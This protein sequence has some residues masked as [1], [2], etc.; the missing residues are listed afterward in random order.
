MELRD[1]RFVYVH[2]VGNL[3]HGQFLLIVERDDLAFALAQVGKRAAQDFA[4]LAAVAQIE[5]ISFVTGQKR[6][7]CGLPL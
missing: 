1:A 2:A 6:R 4:L 5:G 3:L 7:L